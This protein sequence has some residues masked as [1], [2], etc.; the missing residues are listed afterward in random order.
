MVLKRNDKFDNLI[1]RFGLLQ[2]PVVR[3]TIEAAYRSVI[4]EVYLRKFQVNLATDTTKKD[5]FS[6]ELSRNA[7]IAD[8][9][10]AACAHFSLPFDDD[11]RLKKQFTGADKVLS[12]ESETLDRSFDTFLREKV[13]LE[14]KEKG[15]LTGLKGFVFFTLLVDSSPFSLILH[16][17]R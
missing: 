12:D 4:V 3:K 10:K 14:A 7:T 2:P 6:V 16:P 17:S 9:R 5:T 15:H 11:T 1:R 8:L 13:V